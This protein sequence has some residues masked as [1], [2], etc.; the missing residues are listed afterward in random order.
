VV[1]AA[2][3]MLKG[4]KYCY[5]NEISFDIFV[6]V[7]RKLD[8]FDILALGRSGKAMQAFVEKDALWMVLFYRDFCKIMDDT[9]SQSFLRNDSFQSRYR[10]AYNASLEVEKSGWFGKESNAPTA[11]KDRMLKSILM[12]T[13]GTC[14]LSVDDERFLLDA[15]C[16]NVIPNCR[17]RKL[18]RTL[19]LSTRPTWKFRRN[20]T[21][22]S[23]SQLIDFF[24]KHKRK[25]HNGKNQPYLLDIPR[26]MS[27]QTDFMGMRG[28]LGLYEVFNA[29]HHLQGH[30]FSYTSGQNS[31]VATLLFYLSSEEAFVAF[32]RIITESLWCV[33]P[34]HQADTS[35]LI[36]LLCQSCLKPKRTSKLRRLDL[37]PSIFSAVWLAS[38]FAHFVRPSVRVLLFDRLLSQGVGWAMRLSILMIGKLGDAVEQCVSWDQAASLVL[39]NS[40]EHWCDNE[41]HCLF[42]EASDY[43]NM[44][45]SSSKMQEIESKL[46]LL[47]RSPSAMNV[48]LH[49]FNHP[50]ML[51]Q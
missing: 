21:F 30:K 35:I 48:L 14:P 11:S 19:C 24:H 1:C 4:K 2:K 38:L 23:K 18:W 22:M 3:E 40:F 25:E 6:M 45:L 31:L 39:R 15:I 13:N 27:D 28:Y 51:L 47:C 49:S 32:L 33:V 46:R 8:T 16:A 42:Q 17:R 20:G 29:L 41:W 37:D 10:D 7:S 44:V 9:C 5:I 26:T 36:N 34:D 50:S 12:R 43:S